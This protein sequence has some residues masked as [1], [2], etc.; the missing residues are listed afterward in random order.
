[1]RAR[2]TS[3]ALRSEFGNRIATSNDGF[4]RNKRAATKA[5]FDGRMII[6]SASGTIFQ[7]AASFLGTATVRCASGRPPLMARTAGTLMT[8]SPS[9]LLLRIKMR[10]GF[11]RVFSGKKT[12]RLYLESSKFGR[13][14]FQRLWTQNQSSG[15]RLTC[16]S[17]ISL[18]HAVNFSIDSPE[19]SIGLSATARQRANPSV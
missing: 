14:V 6:S 18:L 1:M 5:D 8:A 10:N 9:Q 15:A 3:S 19:F 16:F 4:R 17:K 13:G 2:K 7:K 12:P 11:S